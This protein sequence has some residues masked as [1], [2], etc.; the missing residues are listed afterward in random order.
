MITSSQS[1]NHLSGTKHRVKGREYFYFYCFCVKRQVY[2]Q[3]SYWNAS[4]NIALGHLVMST[5][6]AARLLSKG[7]LCGD[8]SKE[9]VWEYLGTRLS[10]LA[11]APAP[12]CPPSQGPVKAF[13][14]FPGLAMLWRALANATLISWLM[15]SCQG[16]LGEKEKQE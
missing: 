6:L 14:E 11:Q 7:I 9:R 3:D 10:G 2:P 8:W 13:P 5:L 12:L 16:S 4:I 1:P 15:R